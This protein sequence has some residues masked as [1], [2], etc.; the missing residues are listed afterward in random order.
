MKKLVFSTLAC[1]AFA[2]S[3]FASNETVD[4]ID[5]FENL[6]FSDHPC[7]FLIL[8]LDRHGNIL[9]HVIFYGSKEGDP[10][11]DNMMGE[12]ERLQGLY[13]RAVLEFDIIAM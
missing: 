11:L 13:P 9:D 8:V 7:Q 2:G 5:V 10:C 3:A 1:V 6:N 12:A 4:N